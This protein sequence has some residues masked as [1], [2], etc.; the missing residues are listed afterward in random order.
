MN[1]ITSLLSN[2]RAR[3]SSHQ[4]V[5]IK[6]LAGRTTYGAALSRKELR[7]IIAEMID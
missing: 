7:S 6:Q 5:A 1:M 4:P 2:I 3:F